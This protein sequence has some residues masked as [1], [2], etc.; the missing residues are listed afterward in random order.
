MTA[1]QLV[2]LVHQEAPQI[3]RM[4]VY[5]TLDLLSALGALRPIYQGTGAA[6]FIL[7]RDGHHHHLV[8]TN[9]DAV[10]ELDECL[11]SGVAETIGRR[12]EF[13]VQGH[14]LELFGLCAGCQGENDG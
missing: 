6:H 14:V 7:L 11:L 12:F 10:I 5:R 2:D 1:D 9:C 4:T 8:C 13:E 3:G